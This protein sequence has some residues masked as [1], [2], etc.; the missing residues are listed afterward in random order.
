MSGGNPRRVRLGTAVFPP[1]ASE[2]LWLGRERDGV[3]EHGHRRGIDQAVIA[4]LGATRSLIHLLDGVRRH[5][6]IEFGV[7]GVAEVRT[8]C[9]T[10]HPSP[11]DRR[12]LE[13]ILGVIEV[14][15]TAKTM[16]TRH[17]RLLDIG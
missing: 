12:A 2:S 6:L 3:E 16:E 11:V 13:D 10:R 9:G 17:G 5:G 15:K 7:H 8:Y 14:V 1:L 4:V